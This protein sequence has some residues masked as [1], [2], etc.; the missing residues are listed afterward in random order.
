MVLAAALALCS[1]TS[2]RAQESMA[3]RTRA[4]NGVNLMDFLDKTSSER[5]Q[6][7]A[8][9]IEEALATSDKQG[10]WRQLENKKLV[11][12]TA[13]Q[14][15]LQGLKKNLSIEIS[16]H[17]AEQVRRVILEAEAVFNPVLDLNFNYDE[18]N[19]YERKIAGTV[20]QQAFVAT[21]PASN[22]TNPNAGP[23]FITLP[24][25]VQRLTGI[26]NVI[27]N[28]IVQTTQVNKE[29]LASRNQPNGPTQTFTY[30]PTSSQPCSGTVAPTS[31]TP[32][33]A[34]LRQ[35]L[36]WGPCFD[37]SVVTTDRD[38]FYDTQGHTFGASW[39]TNLLF[40][41]E[42]PIGRNF[43]PYAIFNTQLKLRQ[44]ESEIA[45]WALETSINSTLLEVNLRY[46]DL[47]QA[48]ENLLVQIDNRQLV[49][50]QSQHTQR[51]Y[52]QNLATTYDKAQIDATLEGARALEELAKNAFIDASNQLATLIEDTGK[53]VRHSIY[54]PSD[55]APWLEQLLAM[56]TKAAMKVALERRP[57]LSQAQI[58]YEA[59]QI[60]REGAAV[61]ARPDVRL[62]AQIQSLQNSSVYG[63]K[64]YWE[65]L[66]A[67][68][69]PDT[70]N[71]SY[72]ISYRY[73]WGN[74]A[75][76]ARLA[77][78]ELGVQDAVLVKRSTHNDVARDVNDA[79]ISLQ[80]ARVRIQREGQRVDAAH[81]AYDSI[82]RLS[83]SEVVNENELI[84]NITTLLQAKLAKIQATIDNKRAEAS[85]LA[86]Q[87]LIA[88]HY[89]GMVAGNPLERLRI[90]QLTEKG[91]LQYFLR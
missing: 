1:V 42:V 33:T 47:V 45:F 65:S 43:G 86:A 87:G 6:R 7:I 70:L 2:G 34:T 83:E 38:V 76:K 58:N 48:L 66:G 57:E 31:T 22:A 44:K 10:T 40:N 67:I 72:G 37:V 13:S 5:E 64:S 52:D 73:P 68:S 21:S 12:L 74:R 24:P 56:D 63:Y 85:L 62:N 60:Q 36:P 54:L 78:A 59:S 18:R 49:E 8:R 26:R 88:T 82:A 46:L 28:P 16:Q 51:L 81:A 90:Q 23:G 32:N 89:A 17:N 53:A 79:L 4:A 71:Q 41:L 14:A 15:A 69:D 75:V 35:Q 11:R 39:A 61:D 80:T 55:Y 3:P 25:D 27:L 20:N 84:I 77:Q 30:G 29:I 91:D 9:Q 19:T 50:R